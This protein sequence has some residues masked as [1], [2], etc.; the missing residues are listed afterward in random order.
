[1][2]DYEM[3]KSVEEMF[4]KLAK[5]NPRQLEIIYCTNVENAQSFRA[6]INRH[7]Q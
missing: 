6:E 5:K 2:Y 3:R 4:F 7:K 1:M